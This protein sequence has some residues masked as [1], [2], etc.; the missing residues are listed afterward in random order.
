LRLGRNYRS[1][2]SI[3][4]A[5]AKLIG[6]EAPGDATRPMQEKIAVHVAPSEW[7]EAEHVAETIESLIGGH[8]MLAANRD[9]AAGA[10]REPLGFADFAVLYRTDAQSAALRD[11]FDRAG[12]PF[13]KSTPAPITGRAAVGAL[14]KVMEQHRGDLPSRIVAAADA[15]RRR[16]DAPDPAALAEAIRWLTALAGTGDEARFQ[17][18]VALSKESD[19]FDARAERVSLLTIHAAKGLEFPVVFVVGMEDG[20]VPF[21]WSGLGGAAEDEAAGSQAAAEERR[22]FYVAMTRAKDRLFLSRAIERSWRGQIRSLP[23]S[24]FLG[25]IP[26]A[27]IDEQRPPRK[28]RPEARQYSLF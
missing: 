4:A 11:A 21:S 8:D 13:K 7:A 10:K 5:A 23:P 26:R 20:L 28:P 19:F 18:Q 14:L 17:E 25:D 9:Q 15:L 12:I 27:L 16:E 1:T 3:V 22:L 24:P 2:G 6:G